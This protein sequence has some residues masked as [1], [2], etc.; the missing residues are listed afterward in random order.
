M[1]SWKSGKL[2]VVEHGEADWIYFSCECGHAKTA[3][4]GHCPG[5]GTLPMMPCDHEGCDCQEYRPKTRSGGFI[6]G[7]GI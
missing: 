5:V 3:H 7:A 6:D 4:D 2:V 1:G